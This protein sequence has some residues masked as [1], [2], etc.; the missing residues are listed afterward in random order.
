M[1]GRDPDLDPEELGTSLTN[2]RWINKG[3]QYLPTKEGGISLLEWPSH[4]E[5]L[6]SIIWFKYRDGTRGTW[7]LLLGQWVGNR[8]TAGRGA[9]F[10]TIPAVKLTSSLTE[11]R[12]ALPKFF[13]VGL[14]SLKSLTLTP[15]QPGRYTPTDEARAEPAF[16]SH[17][18]TIRSNQHQD[19]WRT[20]FELNR[21]QDFT[22]VEEGRTWT[23]DEINTY[24]RPLVREFNQEARKFFRWPNQYN[25]PTIS[26][27]T[28]TRQYLAMCEEVGYNNI[29]ATITPPTP[30]TDPRYSR[31]ATREMRRQGWW[32]HGGIGSQH[33]GIPEPIEAGMPQSGES[34]RTGLGHPS[35]RRK[36]TPKTDTT[37][38]KL[39]GVE[40]QE[41]LGG[42]KVFGYRQERDGKEY[43]QESLPTRGNQ[44]Q[45]RRSCS[46]ITTAPAQFSDGRAR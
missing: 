11:H 13:K 36:T 29:N 6:N 20:H 43:L 45:L 16:D 7:K 9:P 24:L 32:G 38:T 19:T 17:R 33:E 2:R 26:R 30:L 27:E 35:R 46:V 40:R 39:V 15:T 41:Q 42:G 12:S 21:L 18:Y 44:N 25:T 14:N 1:W 34:A 28:L 3:V 10:T 31:F 8:F 23:R 22:V 4:V 5:A 37:L